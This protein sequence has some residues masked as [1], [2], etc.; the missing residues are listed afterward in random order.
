MSARLFSGLSLTLAVAAGL[1]A[2]VAVGRADAANEDLHALQVQVAATAPA[3]SVEALEE[4]DEGPH[5]GERMNA[6]ARRFAGLWYA[7]CSD[8]Y[9]LAEYEIHSMKEIVEWIE[10]LE[11]V[12]N[13]VNVNGVL[14]AL[15]NTQLK[16]MDDAVEA[17]DKPAF[18]AAY[19]ETMKACNACHASSGHPF[20]RITIPERKPVANRIYEPVPD[21]EPEVV[22]VSRAG[23]GEN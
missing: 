15:R 10:P 3:R 12:E 9:E 17:K 21:A 14:D 5:L 16:A 22:K 11:K 18:E 13:G 23:P 2:V 19:R 6:F 8:N 1:A 20:I 7:G 4:H